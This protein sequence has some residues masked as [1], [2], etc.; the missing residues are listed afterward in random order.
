MT[1]SEPSIDISVIVVNYHSL[2][3]MKKCIDHLCASQFQGRFEILVVNN[4]PGD[5]TAEVLAADYPQVIYLEP[6]SNLGFGPACNYGF[7]RA[8]G[9][10]HLLVNPDAFVAP[11]ALQK[12]YDYFQRNPKV[13]VVGVKLTAEDGGWHPSARLFPTVIDK[14]VIMA[15]L[16]AKYPKHRFFGRMDHTWWDHSEPRAVDWVVGAF[17]MIRDTTLRQLNGF[18]ARFFIYFEEMEFCKRVKMAGMEVHFVP[19]VTVRHVGGVSSSG[20]HIDPN[21]VEGKQITHFR[22]F[23]EALYYAK[24]WGRPGAAVMLGVEWAWTTL[25]LLRNRMG[26]SPDHQR[27]AENLATYARKI[28]FALSETSWGTVVPPHPWPA[29]LDAYPTW[30]KLS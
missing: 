14:L 23:A 16:S 11:D 30:R 8:K 17:F 29:K 26:S 4:S 1:H 24:Y 5:G 25:R 3:E 2:H 13:G 9:A 21:A 7:A 20:K 19:S 15:G 27:K 18:D 10:F 28:R 6:G 12:S 22:L